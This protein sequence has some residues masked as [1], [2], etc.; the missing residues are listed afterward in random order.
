MKLCRDV[1]Y[2]TVV[3]FLGVAGAWAQGTTG[4]HDST[5]PSPGFPSVLQPYRPNPVPPV[6]LENS[7]R[8]HEL[9]RDG[10]LRLSLS[11]ALALAIENNLDIAVQRFVHPIAQADILRASSGQA[12]RGVRGALLPS[13]L[14]AGALG[15]GVNQAGGTGVS[16]TQAES[17]A[18]AA[19]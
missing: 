18:A 13:G 3:F 17:A 4:G 1:S 11:E 5:R 12:A 15:V 2:G 14:S 8:I 19:P 6:Q 7:N 16:A 10:R 9:I